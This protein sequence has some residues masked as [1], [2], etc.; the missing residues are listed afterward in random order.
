[1]SG[2]PA[3][4]VCG[5]IIVLACLYHQA[6]VFWSGFLLRPD[7]FDIGKILDFGQAGVTSACDVPGG[8]GV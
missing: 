2:P 8:R 3:A 7:L 4:P 1:M 6:I 5:T